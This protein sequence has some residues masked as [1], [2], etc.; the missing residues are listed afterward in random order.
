MVSFYVAMIEG[1]EAAVRKV[2]DENPSAA[3]T[4]VSPEDQ[5]W[6]R[7][8]PLSVAACKGYL[9]IVELLLERGADIH[10][11][12]MH[13]DDALALAADHGH[14]DVV[15]LLI[16]KGADPSRRGMH[17][18]NALMAAARTGRAAVVE[19]LLEQNRQPL[20]ARDRDGPIGGK[21]AL[22]LACKHGWLETVTLLLR[23]G[24]DPFIPDDYGDEPLK[25]VDIES[26]VGE[27]LEVRREREG[28]GSWT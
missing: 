15:A 10:A 9:K 2:L 28:G 25:Y 8:P 3:N 13:G 22:F 27:V 11:V 1:K 19:L 16:E 23:A 5:P 20:N 6:W 24:A 17:G 14:R 7:V 12:N 21:T 4:D 26:D 18:R